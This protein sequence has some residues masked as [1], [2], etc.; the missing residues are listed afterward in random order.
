MNNR[1]S[2]LTNGYDPLRDG[3]DPSASGSVEYLSWMLFRH[4]FCALSGTF[5]GD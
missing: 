2:D 4:A 5:A 3:Y 1:F